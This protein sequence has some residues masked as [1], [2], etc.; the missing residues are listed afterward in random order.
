MCWTL[1]SLCL[2]GAGELGV[3]P[4]WDKALLISELW[5]VLGGDKVLVIGELGFI[6][7]WD[8]AMSAS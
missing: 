4:G 1:D 6:P 2:L 8:E 3:I 5:F 7:G